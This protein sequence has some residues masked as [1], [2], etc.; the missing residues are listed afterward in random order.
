MPDEW[1][2]LRAAP[3][4]DM[5]EMRGVSL[6]A[7]LPPQPAWP[8]PYDAAPVWSA[9]PVAAPVPHPQAEEAV[10]P[11][12]FQGAGAWAA[13]VAA[14]L[15]EP[16]APAALQEQWSPR[17]TERWPEAAD[18]ANLATDLYADAGVAGGQGWWTNSPGA[19]PDLGSEEWSRFL[20]QDEE[21][22][23]SE[24]PAA[25][26]SASWAFLPDAMLQESGGRDLLNEALQAGARAGLL[27]PDARSDARAEG[28]GEDA[29][30]S[31]AGLGR[32]G[33]PNAGPEGPDLL[34]AALAAGERA[35]L[36]NR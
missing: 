19:A 28:T 29:R 2:L 31:P 20:A 13:P 9:G 33:D 27:G 18:V 26:A 34:D 12:A 8:G 7:A 36:M 22:D 21:L 30:P 35:G 1:D 17:R 32:V 10:A 4:Y 15:V 11:H 5:E 16:P 24:F 23:T 25:S 3:D 14:S 6:P